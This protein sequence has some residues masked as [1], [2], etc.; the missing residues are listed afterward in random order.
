[1]D[2]RKESEFGGGRDH[3]RAPLVHFWCL[4][5]IVC[6]VAKVVCPL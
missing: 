5:C 6:P 3:L 2:K 4:S 1:M